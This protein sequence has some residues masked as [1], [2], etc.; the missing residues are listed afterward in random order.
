MRGRHDKVNAHNVDT[1]LGF[2]QRPRLPPRTI[3]HTAHALL[4]CLNGRHATPQVMDLSSEAHARIY[5]N[6]LGVLRLLEEA[7]SGI[8]GARS[9]CSSSPS[10]TT[11]CGST[12]GICTSAL[13]TA[14]LSAGTTAAEGPRGLLPL[15]AFCDDGPNDAQMLGPMPT[16]T[17]RVPG[18]DAPPSGCC[19]DPAHHFVPLLDS[20]ELVGRHGR[21]LSCLVLGRLGSSLKQ[22]LQQHSRELQQ[23][24]HKRGTPASL[25]GQGGGGR[26]IHGG[27]R[28]GGWREGPAESGV[29]GG[30]LPMQEVKGMVRQVLHALDYM[31]R[32]GGV[33]GG[34]AMTQYV[35][36]R[37]VKGRVRL[38]GQ[39]GEWV[40]PC[41]LAIVQLAVCP[42]PPH[43]LP[44]AP[45]PPNDCLPPSPLSLSCHSVTSVLSIA[46][47]SRPTL[48]PHTRPATAT[49]T[50]LP[51]GQALVALAQPLD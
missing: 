16:P 20:F 24:R 15:G 18:H 34:G 39:V 11:T 1:L 44:T 49:A 8:R 35:E 40:L 37:S 5:R 14:D 33:E 17:C 30:G 42:M 3:P 7:N 51:M 6:E 31:H 2:L 36:G 21:P 46:T 26:P 50:C 12:P 38:E 25:G 29:G 28:P 32:W 4:P 45:S 9:S 22:Q 23:G 27:G 13:S 47:S 10:G 19:R 41:S 48:W 43:R